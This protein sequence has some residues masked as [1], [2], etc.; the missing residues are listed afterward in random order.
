M[1]ILTNNYRRDGNALVQSLYAGVSQG[2]ATVTRIVKPALD[3][4]HMATTRTY[5]PGLPRGEG[6]RVAVLVIGGMETTLDE[7]EYILQA[8]QDKKFVPKKNSGD[9]AEMCRLVAERRNEQITAQ[10]VYF[11]ANPSERPRKRTVRLHLP[12]GYKMAPTSEPGLNIR[13]R[14]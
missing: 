10:R 9:I 14:A 3:G 12:V 5:G 4:N 6:G 13:V 1:E 7:M 11:R 8:K 2:G